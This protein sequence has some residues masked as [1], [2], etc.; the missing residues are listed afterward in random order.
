MVGG[1]E[2]ESGRRPFFSR[3]RRR[4]S[5]LALSRRASS[6]GRALGEVVTTLGRAARA[7]RGAVPSLSRPKTRAA[8]PQSG[9]GEFRVG[10]SPAGDRT[11]MSLRG[12]LTLGAIALAIVPIPW[13]LLS[14]EPDSSGAAIAEPRTPPVASPPATA[15]LSDAVFEPPVG[16][17]A[18]HAPAG[19]D[20]LRIEYTLDPELTDEVWKVLDRGRVALGHV[21]LMDP[22]SGELL[23]YVSTDPEHFPPTRAYPAASLVKVVTAAALLDVEPAAAKRPCRYVGNP[24]RLDRRSLDPPRRGGAE[25]SLRRALATSNNKCFAQWAIH[26]IGGVRLLAAIRQ[27]GLLRPAAPEHPS[28][29]VSDPGDDRLELGRLGSG[30]GGLRIT[31]LHAVQLAGVLAHGR[32]VQPSWVARIEDAAGA[33][34]AIPARA[35]SVP[36]LTEDLSR[37]L[38]SMLTDTTRRGTARK[39]FRTRR[40]RPLLG[41]V[42]VAGKTGSLNGTDPKGRYEW[43]IGVAPADAPTLAIATLAVQGP[44]FWMSASQLA[45]EV[46]KVAFCPKGVCS[47]EPPQARRTRTATEPVGG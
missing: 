22:E 46:L 41:G 25:M 28:G 11:R 33:E 1:D 7:W 20:G 15:T 3:T 24:Y 9:R 10:R 8:A 16:R 6:V 36:I 17:G 21:L 2:P 43:F 42:T 32:R 13:W 5:L 40:G 4:R 14:G 31:P 19:E 30:L 12:R 29:V 47:D 34:L 37:E 18:L 35:E 44:L 45:A 27:F 39:A 26:E 38:R 23:T